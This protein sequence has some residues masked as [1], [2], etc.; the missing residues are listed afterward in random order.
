MLISVINS[1]DQKLVSET[2]NVARAWK[3]LQIVIEDLAKQGWLTTQEEVNQADVAL[4]AI[5]AGQWDPENEHLAHMVSLCASEF[6]VNIPYVL[7]HREEVAAKN[8]RS[9]TQDEWCGLD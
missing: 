5:F 1:A 2:L 8:R 6:S 4:T 9:R 3:S 7:S